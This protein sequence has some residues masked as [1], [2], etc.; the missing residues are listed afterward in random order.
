VTSSGADRRR[1]ELEA[2]YCRIYLGYAPA[3]VAR[4]FGVSERTIRRWV[5]DVRRNRGNAIAGMLRAYENQVSE[6]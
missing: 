3:D 2:A 4:R 1:R 5:A 6:S